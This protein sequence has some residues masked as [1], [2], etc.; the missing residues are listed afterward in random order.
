MSQKCCAAIAASLRKWLK[1]SHLH[2]K[3]Y[4]SILLHSLR[5]HPLQLQKAVTTTQILDVHQLVP[6][7]PEI[8]QIPLKLLFLPHDRDSSLFLRLLLVILSFSLPTPSPFMELYQMPSQYQQKTGTTFSS[9]PCILLAFF[10][11]Q[12]MHLSFLLQA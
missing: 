7:I 12:T 6:R 10:I 9:N 3:F 8:T 2:T 11:L 1:A 5:L 4:S